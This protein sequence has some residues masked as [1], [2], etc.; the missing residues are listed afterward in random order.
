MPDELNLPTDMKGCQALILAQA[1]ANAEQAQ[2]NAQQSE[3][4]RAIESEMEKLRKLVSHFINGQQSISAHITAIDAGRSARG[5][6]GVGL[7]RQQL[8]SVN[9]LLGSLRYGAANRLDQTTVMGAE[10]SAISIEQLDH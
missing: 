10:A 9:L 8:C 1:A 3:R 6:L 7:S 4:S 5:F 2:T